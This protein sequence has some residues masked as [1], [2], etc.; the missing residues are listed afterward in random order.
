MKKAVASVKT[1]AAKS[2]T[3]NLVV[4]TQNPTSPFE[5]IS[6]LLHHLHLH[7]CVELTRRLLM[8]I[9]SLPTGQIATALL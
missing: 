1:E 3:P 9:S 2:T 6:D 4:P 5:D 8:S 7:A